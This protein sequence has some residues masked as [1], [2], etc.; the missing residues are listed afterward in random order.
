[1]IE[2]APPDTSHI[3]QA[4]AAAGPAR[5]RWGA[6]IATATAAYHLAMQGW[7][8]YKEFQHRSAYTVALGEGDEA[9]PLV[10]QWLIDKMPDNMQRSLS[11]R[12]AT[13]QPAGPVDLF[14]PEAESLAQAKRV[15]RL[16][17]DGTRSQQVD[18]NGH[19]IKVQLEDDPSSTSGRDNEGRYI[20][21]PKR[22]L[23]IAENL[24]GRKAVAGFLQDIADSITAGRRPPRLLA[25]NRWGSSWR[26][27]MHLSAR[28]LE[29]VVL[30][31]GQLDALHTDMARFL[32]SEARYHEL[33]IPWHRGYLLHGPPGTGKTSVFRALCW[34]L[35]L[36]VYYV[37]LSDL[38][39]DGTLYDLM[40]QVPERC[41][42]LVED[43]DVAHAATHRDD[44]QANKV[45]LAGLLNAF[46][47]ALTPHGMVLGMTT[48]NRATLD[49]ALV[50]P[51]RVD[52]ELALTF[53]VPEQADRLIQYLTG[54][55]PNYRAEN[56]TA[57]FPDDMT[58]AELVGIVT[59]HMHDPRA[60]YQACAQYIHDRRHGVMA[61]VV[62]D[63]HH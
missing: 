39:S 34:E 62:A 32:A 23:F 15:I 46:D 54:K 11:A 43:V 53:L 29:S 20:F 17:Y 27:A 13:E 31:A 45:T 21:R 58:A 48:N 16:Y 8:M 5:G 40:R 37:P 44:D 60:A 33:S 14:A 36:D 4:R 38:D 9:F 24:A 2:Q 28:T 22:I 57:G 55:D 47:G 26:T 51:G 25:A 42:V 7:R 1:M 56:M 61:E 49:D 35:G 59:R 3:D 52:H 30:P 6:R 19:R 41:A 63:G 10:Q 18:I 50:R 12:T